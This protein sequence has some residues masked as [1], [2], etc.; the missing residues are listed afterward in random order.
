MIARRLPCLLALMWVAPLSVYAKSHGVTIVALGDS[1]T[2]GTPFFRS[3]LEQPPGGS[4][5]PQG[6]YGYWMMHRHPDWDVVNCGIAGQRSDE[7]RAR[8]DDIAQ[9]HAQY[10]VILAGV[11]DIAQDTPLEEIEKNLAW[12][13]KQAMLKETMPIA[14]T[15][16]PFDRATPGQSK[17]IDALNKWILK[18]AAEI[19][20]PLINLHAVVAHPNDPHRLNGSPDGL[21]PDVGGY[22]QMGL[23]LAALIEKLER[24]KN[25]SGR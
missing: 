13:Y 3:P 12:M 4:G 21:H 24:E 16:L 6:Q 7:I 15:V 14:V 25:P 18:N 1:T 17:A 10:V 2:A 9:Y 22:R 11:N 23:A 19:P 5:D 8:F 20:I